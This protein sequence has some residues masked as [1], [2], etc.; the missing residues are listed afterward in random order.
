MQSGLNVDL[1][2]QI[3][4]PFWSPYIRYYDTACC[5]IA[6][7]AVNRRLQGGCQV[8]IACFAE[9]NPKDHVISL[10]GLVGGIDGKTLLEASMA[11]SASDAEQLGQELADKLLS[12][13]AGAILSAV[14]GNDDHG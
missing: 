11:G 12:M 3:F 7:R 8:P 4:W 5:V 2:I 9:L 10:R 14:L 6:E 1:M 13:G